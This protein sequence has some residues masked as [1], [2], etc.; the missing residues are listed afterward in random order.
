MKKRA[1]WAAWAQ[2]ASYR[3]KVRALGAYEKENKDICTWEK[4]RGNA[5]EYFRESTSRGKKG[6]GKVGKA[7][8][9]EGGR[10][11]EREN[12]RESCLALPHLILT[13][14]SCTVLVDSLPKDLVRG[15]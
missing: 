11:G 15:D 8:V 14:T 9:C 10:G 12:L 2:E 1:S 7:W 3:G 5:P 13:L 6:V 4:E